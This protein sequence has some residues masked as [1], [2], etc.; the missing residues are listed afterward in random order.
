[1]SSLVFRF[2]IAGTGTV[3]ARVPVSGVIPGDLGHVAVPDEQPVPGNR[4][5]DGGGAIGRPTEAVGAPAP[6]GN[7]APATAVRRTA[8]R[9]SSIEL[10]PRLLVS[11]SML[12][13]APGWVIVILMVADW[14]PR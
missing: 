11:G 9:E 13:M 3:F 8:Q 2:G 1:M 6:T 4:K 7:K 12:C 10:L 14:M 5:A